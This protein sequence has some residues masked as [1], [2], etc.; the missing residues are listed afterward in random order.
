MNSFKKF[1]FALVLMS[2]IILLMKISIDFLGS[3]NFFDILCILILTYFGYC[4]FKNGINKSD[5]KLINI[6]SIDPSKNG[7]VALIWFMI[8]SVIWGILL[9]IRINE[10]SMIIKI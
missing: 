9:Y 6:L 8:F 10:V 4:I 1:I 5:I 3:N 7:G 2:C